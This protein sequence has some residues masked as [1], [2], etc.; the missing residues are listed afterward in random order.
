MPITKQK[1]K[2]GVM[3]ITLNP[4]YWTFA[5]EMLWG[6]NTFF[7]KHPSIKEKYDVK[8]LLWS[9]IPEDQEQISLKLAEYLVSRNEVKTSVINQTQLQFI[10][11]DDKKAG[12]DALINGV[13]DIRKQGVTIFPTEPVEW[14]LPTLLR[15]NLFLQ[16][17]EKLRK[18]DYVFY[19]DI[20]MRVVNV[21]GDEILG[22]GLTATQHPM[23]ALRKEYCPPYEPNKESTAY[24]PRSGRIIDDNGK[25]RFI[26]LYYAGGLKGGK[27]DEFIKAMKIIKKNI[28]T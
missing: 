14:P 26:P 24:I 8:L 17:D 1:I 11:N 5:N 15:Y 27:T 22:D 7:L 20:D 18:Y 9:D 19:C 28:D 6:L 23:Y 3:A 21:V 13:I 25:S 2:I 4:P 12:V 16:Q 10:V